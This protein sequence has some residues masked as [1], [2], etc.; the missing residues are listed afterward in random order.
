MKKESALSF[1]EPIEVHRIVKLWKRF[2]SG[3]GL[4]FDARTASKSQVHSVQ[5]VRRDNA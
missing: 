3:S 1:S 2:R 5:D 4:G